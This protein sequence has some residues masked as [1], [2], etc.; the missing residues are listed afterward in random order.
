[1][2]ATLGALGAVEML[3]SAIGSTMYASILAYASSKGSKYN[4]LGMHFMVAAVLVIMGLASGVTS[5]SLPS[6]AA[7]L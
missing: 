2:Q 6:A 7:F 5:L 3:T 1:M 4:F